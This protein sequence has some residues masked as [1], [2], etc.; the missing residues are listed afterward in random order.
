[1]QPSPG[2]RNPDAHPLH[3]LVYRPADAATSFVEYLLL[4]VCAAAILLAMGL[5]TVDVLMR[6]GFSRPLGWSFDVIMLYLMPS[7]YYL[8]FAY[9]MKIGAHLSVDFFAERLPRTL[10]RT[11]YPAVLVVS[12]VVIFY[13]SFLIGRE[14]LASYRAGHT[15]FGSIRWPTWPTGVIISLSF[16][17]LAVR[18]VLVALNVAM[19]RA[20]G[21][22]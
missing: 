19:G 14:A 3:R 7:A 22:E 6:Y 8:A 5:T 12:A 10:V 18:L 9:A 15:I 4:T 17:V 16:L 20:M 2:N 21:R 13:I 11:A 1:M